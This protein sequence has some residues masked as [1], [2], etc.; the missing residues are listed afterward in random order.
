MLCPIGSL[1]CLC[2]NFLYACH[3]WFGLPCQSILRPVAAEQ[4]TCRCKYYKKIQYSFPHNNSP[5]MITMRIFNYNA[6]LWGKPPQFTVCDLSVKKSDKTKRPAQS[7]GRLLDNSLFCYLNYI[8]VRYHIRV[9]YA[10]AT[11]NKGSCLCNWLQIRIICRGNRQC[12][13]IA[14][15]F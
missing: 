7:A 8:S 15:S 10:G 14:V 2:L 9:E 12:N 5:K 1:R 6:M 3:S 4:Q 11:P 13:R